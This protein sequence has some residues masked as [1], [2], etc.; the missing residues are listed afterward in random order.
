MVASAAATVMMIGVLLVALGLE[1][2]GRISEDHQPWYLIGGVLAVMIGVTGACAGFILV[3]TRKTASLVLHINGLM[4][5]TALESHWVTWRNIDDISAQSNTV[6]VQ[7]N[8]S[9]YLHIDAKIIGTKGKPLADRLAELKRLV[10][11][12]TIK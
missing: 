8:P 11:L 3:I 10:L 12:G 4:Y 6:T 7:I 1:S 5:T 9:G 2:T